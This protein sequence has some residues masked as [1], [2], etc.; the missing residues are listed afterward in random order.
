MGWGPGGGERDRTRK[1]S[2]WSAGARVKRDEVGVIGWEE[3]RRIGAIAYWCEGVKW[4]PW[5]NGPSST[6][7]LTRSPRPP[8]R[9]S[10]TVRGGDK[11]DETQGRGTV[12]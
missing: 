8:W 1:T 9:G 4:K 2:S 3:L 12:I 10:L 6:G 11:P 5:N 7:T